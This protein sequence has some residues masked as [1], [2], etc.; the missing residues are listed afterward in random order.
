MSYPFRR[1]ISA[2]FARSSGVFRVFPRASVMALR[3][4]NLSQPLSIALEKEAF[5]EKALA[6]RSSHFN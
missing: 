6:S 5:L 1:R 2:Y 4:M 3:L